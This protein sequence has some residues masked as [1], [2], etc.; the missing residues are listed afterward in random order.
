METRCRSAPGDGH[1]DPVLLCRAVDSPGHNHLPPLKRA[2]KREVCRWP[3]R[4]RESWRYFFRAQLE[5]PSFIFTHNQAGVA[6]HRNKGCQPFVFKERFSPSPAARAAIEMPIARTLPA[7]G[8]GV[9]R[10]HVDNRGVVIP[11]V[12]DVEVDVVHPEV[13]QTR[14]SERVIALFSKPIPSAIWKKWFVVKLVAGTTFRSFGLSPAAPG[15]RTVR[16]SRSDRRWRRPVKIDALF[17]SVADDVPAMLSFS[18]QSDADPL[19][20]RQT[21]IHPMQTAGETAVTSRSRYTASLFFLG[22][23]PPEYVARS[24]WPRVPGQAFCRA[25]CRHPGRR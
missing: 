13:S 14:S 22:R 5:Q 16:W 12:V 7:V 10:F 8:P 21:P 2:S 17:Q 24:V 3:A 11:D 25:I 4:Y 18:V 20:D 15:Q 19:T 1:N 9:Q 23:L 6:L